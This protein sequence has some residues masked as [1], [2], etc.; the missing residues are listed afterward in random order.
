MRGDQKALIAMQATIYMSNGTVKVEI[1]A[2]E[3]NVHFMA[4]AKAVTDPSIQVH[5]EELPT[6]KEI[7]R[8]AQKNE[9][10]RLITK[11]IVGAMLDI[12]KRVAKAT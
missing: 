1:K 11:G 3:D 4:K 6:S 5:D 12:I 9:L 10:K 8:M 7:R 2:V